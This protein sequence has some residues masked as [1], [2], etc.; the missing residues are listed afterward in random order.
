VWDAWIV[1]AR[2]SRQWWPPTRS[3][4]VHGV[5]WFLRRYAL[6]WALAALAVYQWWRRR[7][8]LTGDL[9]LWLALGTLAVLPQH[10]WEY[11]W[12]V[13][14]VPLALLAARGA[15]WLVVD[16]HL[17]RRWATAVLAGVLVLGLPLWR[18]TATNAA[19]YVRHD[20]GVTVDGRRAIAQD[21]YPDT[22]A[23]DEH[24][25]RLES[26]GEVSR[27]VY[28]FGNPLY[29]L[30]TG[31]PYPARYHGWAFEFYNPSRWRELVRE[32]AAAQPAFIFIDSD[33]ADLV[34]RRSPELTALLDER[35]AVW[36][37]DESGVWYQLR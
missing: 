19:R 22:V 10:W 13:L 7:D 37:S 26:T 16:A 18:S 29:H 12:F 32:L 11:L 25:A 33:W 36:L 21:V 2:E 15:D 31:Q 20:L 23:I 1:L 14:F 5:T 6:L 34:R 4:F 9:V 28:V 27:G 3:D 24:V 8:P 30:D 35:Y 17:D